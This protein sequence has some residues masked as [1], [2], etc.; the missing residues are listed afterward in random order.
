MVLNATLIRALLLAW[1]LIGAPFQAAQASSCSED[2]AFLSGVTSARIFQAPVYLRLITSL[3]NDQQ[4]LTPEQ[5]EKLA[6]LDAP[7]DPFALFDLTIK[8]PQLTQKYREAFRLVMGFETFAAEEWAS[9]KKEFVSLG[10]KKAIGEEARTT[11]K[12]ETAPLAFPVKLNALSRKHVP[13]GLRVRFA[14]INGRPVAS[15]VGDDA[16]TGITLLDLQ[17][18]KL[19]IIEN[20][21]DANNA[22]PPTI[23]AFKGKDYMFNASNRVEIFELPNRVGDASYFADGEYLHEARIDASVL[24][25]DGRALIVIASEEKNKV[26]L[27][28]FDPTKKGA[29]PKTITLPGPYK[30]QTLHRSPMGIREFEDR[31]LVGLVSYQSKT[32]GPH[33][34]DAFVLHVID[35]FEGKRIYSVTVKDPY[36]PAHNDHTIPVFYKV[37]SKIRVALP[38]IGGVRVYDPINKKD[39]G[40]I[41]APELQ[42]HI[43]LSTYEEGG[44]VFGVVGSFHRDE[45][46]LL[47][48]TV[49]VFNLSKMKRVGSMTTNPAHTQVTTPIV[50]VSVGPKT[51]LFWGSDDG[52]VVVA[53]PANLSVDSSTR[54]HSGL[55]TFIIP[56]PLHDEDRTTV[57]LIGGPAFQDKAQLMQLVGP[58]KNP[59]E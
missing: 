55:I 9:L 26:S 32:V 48:W 12:Q 50:P 5:L 16:R 28:P 42:G 30:E 19:D 39:L 56:L 35:P 38:V 18:M 11:A 47:E 53:D 40:K 36:L 3:V 4:A 15:F 54:V 1:S 59:N 25:R 7:A 13:G 29:R 10:A 34:H 22:I 33:E 2:M 37:K 20:T 57:G 45:Q 49:T 58:A 24:Q 43:G 46:Y 23:F 17:T 6:L 8:N 27:L 14:S 21:A 52:D 41:E 51:Y 31:T 44:E